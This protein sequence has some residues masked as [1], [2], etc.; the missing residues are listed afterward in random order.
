MAH[1]ALL[2]WDAPVGSTV[3]SYNVKRATVA[4]GPF[5]VVGT[6]TGS[7]ATGNTYTDT[8]GLVEGTTYFYEVTAVNPAG[9]SIP[10][11][12]VSGLVA[13]LVPGAPINLVA[14]FS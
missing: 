2:T 8:A 11:A 6:V 14:T 1:S 5:T 13:F 10:S 3:A 7:K 12:E 9:E 4:A